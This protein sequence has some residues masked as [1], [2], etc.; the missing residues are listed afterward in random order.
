MRTDPAATPVADGQIVKEDLPFPI[1]HYPRAFGTFLAFA[2][3]RRHVPSLCECARPALQNLLS[4]RPD[5]WATGIHIA[6]PGS[7]FPAAIACA[8]RKWNGQ[9][10][11][12]VRFAEGVCHQC[13]G[14]APSLVYA[15]GPGSSPFV[16]TYGWYVNQAYL[17]LGIL[18]HRC[19]YLADLCPPVYQSEI[20]TT[21]RLEQE[22]RDQCMRLLDEFSRAHRP[23][24]QPASSPVSPDLTGDDIRRMME[25]RQQASAAR[26]RLKQQIEAAAWQEFS[27]SGRIHAGM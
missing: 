4:L 8:L 21:R 11:L 2:P 23:E 3:S 24:H 26:R 20:E 19:A 16:E 12:P 18:P 9:G 17:R 22:F 1:V 27:A 10:P 25:S 13:T 7:W 5:L 14:A 15:A 6:G